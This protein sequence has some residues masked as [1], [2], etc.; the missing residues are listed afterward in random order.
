MKLILTR[1]AETPDETYGVLRTEHGE[2]LA[3]TLEHPWRDNKRMVSRIPAGTYVVFR[4]FSPKRRYFLWE[5]R[6]VRGRS[7]IQ[8]H[9]GNTTADTDGCILVGL[10]TGILGGKLAVLRSRDAFKLLMNKTAMVDSFELEV[11]DPVNG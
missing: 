2:M 1:L 11:I 10:T 7:N 6:F 5:I 9:I 4:R 8:I 3:V